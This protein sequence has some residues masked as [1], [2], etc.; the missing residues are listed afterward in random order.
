MVEQDGSFRRLVEMVREQRPVLTEGR[1]G[2]PPKHRVPTTGM[3]TLPMYE[4]IKGLAKA[5]TEQGDRLVS[6]A[7]VYNEAALILIED[8]HD[9]LGDEMRLPS[10][11]LSISGILGLRE[12]VK[13]PVLTPLGD[14]PFSKSNSIRTTLY[15]DESIWDILMD[16]SLRFGLQLRRPLHVHRLV[17][18]GAAWYLAGIEPHPQ[19]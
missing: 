13:R 5:R 10:G 12:L 4:R 6:V 15:F 9:L 16:L 1:T 3:F 2:R 7:D 8:L 19:K 14:L 11:T 18:L 17:D